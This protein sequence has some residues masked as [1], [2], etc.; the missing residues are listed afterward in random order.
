MLC[1]CFSSDLTWW[2][3]MIFGSNKFSTKHLHHRTNSYLYLCLH[4]CGL[5][6]IS[7][8]FCVSLLPHK[9][10]NS[11]S[12]VEGIHWHSKNKECHCGASTMRHGR[13][14]IEP[15]W[16]IQL[17]DRRSQTV[18]K[19]VKKPL[20]SRSNS[21]LTN[22]L[23]ADVRNSFNILQNECVCGCV[24]L[25]VCSVLSPKS[26]RLISVS[27]FYA[28]LFYWHNWTHLCGYKCPNVHFYL[29]L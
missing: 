12:Y 16:Y 1:Y 17:S 2:L 26:S 25:S 19:A 20:S 23:H 11:I 7:L 8:F 27:Y 10:W 18:Q 5:L 22:T 3:T 14:Y 24:R 13:I 4:V 9:S 28:A 21:T 6:L 29:I 15:L